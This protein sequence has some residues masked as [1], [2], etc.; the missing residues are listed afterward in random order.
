M[1]AEK[2]GADGEMAG[3]DGIS[4]PMFTCYWLARAAKPAWMQV[5]TMM[6]WPC[7]NGASTLGRYLCWM[8]F[9]THTISFTGT[10]ER[11][12]ALIPFH[13]FKLLNGVVDQ[14]QRSS[15]GSFD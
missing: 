2:A 8:I 9:H 14:H 10:L 4:V 13:L 5:A 12:F 6:F 7:E 3:V 11:V 1:Q 15:A